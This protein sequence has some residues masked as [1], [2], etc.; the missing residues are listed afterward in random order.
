MSIP[1]ARH[2]QP[3][4]GWVECSCGRRHWGLLGAAG[5]LVFRFGANGVPEAAILQHRA[6]WSDQGG[7][8]GV[9]GGAMAPGESPLDGALREAFE[10]AGILASSIE[11]LTTHVLDHGAWQYTTVIARAITAI[12]PRPT[13]AESM[14]VEWVQVAD[15]DS[16]P[17]LPAFAD[18]WPGLLKL[19]RPHGSAA[20]AG[21]RRTHRPG[22]SPDGS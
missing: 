8:W 5:L 15:V 19:A 11:V 10:E 22:V 4:D 9:P 1:A 13:D 7:T 6:P 18:A 21:S 14:A 3:G 16:L 12:D 20:T 17:L 2:L